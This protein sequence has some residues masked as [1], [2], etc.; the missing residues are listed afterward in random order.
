MSAGQRLGVKPLESVQLR[1]GG[2]PSQA[3]VLL[4]A[5]RLGLELENDVRLAADRLRKY[6][7]PVE[8]EFQPLPKIEDPPLIHVSDSS[9]D[10]DEQ[11]VIKSMPLL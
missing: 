7:V 3:T 2:P 8:L 1:L 10:E 9:S 11:A 5:A 6:K 4:N